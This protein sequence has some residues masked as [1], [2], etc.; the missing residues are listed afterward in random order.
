[1]DG[2]PPVADGTDEYQV[3]VKWRMVSQKDNRK[4]L[5][6]PTSGFKPVNL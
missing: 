6:T 5:L 3:P 1:M 2:S 4:I